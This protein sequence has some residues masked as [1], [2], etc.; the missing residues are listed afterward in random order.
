M[1]DLE[2]AKKILGMEISRDRI[3]DKFWLSQENYVLKILESFNMAEARPITTLLACHFRLSS[4]QF[5][6]SQEEE[7]EMSRVPYA[8][9][10]D[11]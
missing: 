7:D 3:I 9:T 2:E 5:P 4:S 8:S 11:H 10:W 6:N 1:K